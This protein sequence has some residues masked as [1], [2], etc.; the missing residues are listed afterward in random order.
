MLEYIK[1]VF[2]VRKYSNRWMLNEI[3]RAR[4][5]SEK[6]NDAVKHLTCEVCWTIIF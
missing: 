3:S 2:N 1:R 4:C 6:V 5:F